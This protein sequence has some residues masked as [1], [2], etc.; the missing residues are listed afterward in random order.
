MNRN[1]IAVSPITSTIR[2]TLCAAA[3]H[4]PVR[5]LAERGLGSRAGLYR[6]ITDLRCALAAHGLRVA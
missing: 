3:T 4:S 1:W 2:M 6:R 5:V